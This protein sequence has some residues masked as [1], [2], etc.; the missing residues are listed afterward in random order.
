MK[1]KQMSS[2]VNWTKMTSCKLLCGVSSRFPLFCMYV[3]ADC[4]ALVGQQLSPI[5]LYQRSS[6]LTYLGVQEVSG[7]A[8]PACPLQRKE[9]D[10]A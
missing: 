4:V 8:C 6:F 9:V 10:G 3:I 5:P 2:S 7:P 1:K